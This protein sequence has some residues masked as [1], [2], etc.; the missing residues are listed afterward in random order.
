MKWRS[1]IDSYGGESSTLIYHY[2]MCEIIEKSRITIP[3]NASVIR[4]DPDGKA[5][6][7]D[8]CMLTHTNNPIFKLE[9]WLYSGSVENR[10]HLYAISHIMRKAECVIKDIVLEDTDTANPMALGNVNMNIMI[11]YHVPKPTEN[12]FK[13][14]SRNFFHSGMSTELFEVADKFSSLPV[15][16]EMICKL[17]QSSK[18]RSLIE[19]QAV[20]Y[21]VHDRL[22]AIFTKYLSERLG[23]ILDDLSISIKLDQSDIA[24]RKE[25][26]LNKNKE[27]LYIGELNELLGE[28]WTREQAIEILKIKKG[29]YSDVRITK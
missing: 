26:E 25:F 11:K 21:E 22:V 24:K 8:K 4:V 13:T 15:N 2:D 27:R 23:I 28:G 17:I 20:P 18:I 5:Q 7:I 9:R 14:F 19:L 3:Y 10:I 6:L 12:E 16:E 1:V 29:N